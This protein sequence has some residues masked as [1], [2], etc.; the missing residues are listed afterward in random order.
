MAIAKK[1][2]EAVKKAQ[3][4]Q[5]VQ[6]DKHQ[7]DKEFEV[8]D[9]VMISTK[10]FPAYGKE[11]ANYIGP[12]PV[13]KKFSPLVYELDLL[14]GTKFHPRFNIEKLKQYHASPERFDTRSVPPPPVVKH[15]EIEYEVEKILAKRLQGKKG[16]KI[17]EYKV[18]WKGYTAKEDTWEPKTNLVG[19]P[20]ALL[21]FETSLK[22]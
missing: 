5:K 19:A 10:G 21:E 8:G 15:G 17:E 9:Q 11:D 20:D 6:F 18:R 4:S 22:T 2:T 16:K 1:A 3:E 13:T 14:A 7:R 12:Y